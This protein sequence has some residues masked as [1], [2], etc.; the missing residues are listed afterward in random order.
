VNPD[1]LLDEARAT[2][3]LDDF[4]PDDF[5]EGL[6]VYC[7]S[8]AEEAQLNEV[9]ALAVRSAVLANLVQRL[10]VVDWAA[11]HD[12]VTTGPGAAI[13]APLVVIGMFRAG[14][15]FL[16]NLL[17]QDP[18]NRS[19][20]RWESGDAVPPP[21]P[22]DHRSGPRV[23]AARAEVEMLEALNPAM[24]TVHHED[25]DGPTECIAVMSQDFKSLS[26]EA[27]ANVPGYGRWLL[28]ADHRSAYAHHRRVLQV[29]QHG[30]VRGRWTLKS[31]HHALAL[32]ALVAEYPDARL[33]LVHRDPPVVGASVCSLIRTFSG[34]FSDADHL[35]Y[36][37]THWPDVLATS[38]ERIEAFRAARPDVPI[39]DVQHA[40]LVARPVETVAA[41]YDAVGGSSPRPLSAPARTAMT[42]FVAAHDPR[43]HGV[44]R[45]DLGD[46]GLDRAAVLDRFAPY[47]D[48][49]AIPLEP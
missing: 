12:D 44:H 46:F 32:D 31:P 48:R 27:I 28:D 49:Y 30:G 40:D 20:L 7:R 17:D 15:T 18:G 29:L 24:A 21:A 34:T 19:L 35:S 3:G 22:A 47:V 37:A 14:T 36:I 39:V 9:G 45:Y 43:R 16:G 6:G 33:V 8:V 2:T 1:D 10:R 4:G 5:R 25:A 26:W 23:D 11:R 13:T 38:I 41:I 42:A